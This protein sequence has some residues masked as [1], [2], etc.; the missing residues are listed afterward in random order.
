VNPS[1]A[2]RYKLG[3]AWSFS[4]SG[5]EKE[6]YGEVTDFYASPYRRDYRTE[7]VPNGLLAVTRRQSYT[8][9]ADY[10]R[11]AL[12]LFAS[13]ALQYER[14]TSNRLYGLM[15]EGEQVSLH[16]LERR[17]LSSAGILRGR[18]SKG[19]YSRRLTASLDYSLRLSRGEQEVQG[20]P[21]EFREGRM[22][23]EPEIRWI[24]VPGLEASWRATFLRRSSVMGEATRLPALWNRVQR[25]EL[26]YTCL[27]MEINVSGEHYVN[28]LGEGQ[29]AGVFFGDCSLR[30]K[31]PGRRQ[32]VLGLSATNLFNR[33]QYRYTLYEALQTYTSR[34]NLRGREALVS[35]QY[36]W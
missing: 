26:S 15:F 14:G 13:L 4:V 18:L 32:L 9:R 2:V 6:G 36:G 28:E 24:P 23:Y 21:V 35:L 30:W 11:T 25:L 19:V 20:E 10:K 34:I 27:G 1:L 16:A 12:E 3:Y 17:N 8:A 22:L 5:G 29:S 31:S 33:Q 7:V